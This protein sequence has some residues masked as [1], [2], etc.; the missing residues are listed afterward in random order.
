MVKMKALPKPTGIMLVGIL[1]VC[2]FLQ[3]LSSAE[4]GS[5]TANSIDDIEQF[6]SDFIHHKGYFVTGEIPL[7]NNEADNPWSSPGDFGYGTQRPEIMPRQTPV[8]EKI[9]INGSHSGRQVENLKAINTINQRDIVYDESQI[10]DS[11]GTDSV[12]SVGL[13]IIGDG[14]P[15]GKLVGKFS[16]DNIEKF[17]DTI[18]L[19]KSENNKNQGKNPDKSHGGGRT[20][21][22]MDIGVS[23][24]TVSAINTIEGGSAVA[25]S[26]IIIKPVQIIFYPSEVDE[27]LR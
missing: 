14:Q 21:N 20:G 16:E 5:N 19:S 27:K 25:T 6:H 13:S 3:G 1:L 17:V 7:S 22:Y 18:L 15:E 23:G 12:N 9:H 4:T 2:F 11:G 10:S 8:Q 24:I 26:N